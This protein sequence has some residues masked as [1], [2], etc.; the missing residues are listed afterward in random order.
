LVS[1]FKEE[2]RN[3]FSIFATKRQPNIVK[4]ISADTYR[5][6]IGQWAQLVFCIKNILDIHDR[7][8]F[9]TI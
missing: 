9:L 8:R 3:L 4:T 7:W 2:S 1:D 5:H 6:I